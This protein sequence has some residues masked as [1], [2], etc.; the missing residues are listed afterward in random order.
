MLRVAVIVGRARGIRILLV[1]RRWV[2]GIIRMCRVHRCEDRLIS[3]SALCHTS[4]VQPIPSGDEIALDRDHHNAYEHEDNCDD[5]Y[6]DDSA[7]G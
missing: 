5:T 3:L 1:K 6:L 7:G 4:L 2:V